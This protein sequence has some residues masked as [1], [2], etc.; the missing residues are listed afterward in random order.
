MYLSDPGGHLSTSGDISPCFRRLWPKATPPIL[1]R[2]PEIQPSAGVSEPPSISAA[3]FRPQG[4]TWRLINFVYGRQEFAPPPKTAVFNGGGIRNSRHELRSSP[5]GRA[6]VYYTAADKDGRADYPGGTNY[7]WR[8][9]KDEHLRCCRQLLVGPPVIIRPAR[10]LTTCIVL[11]PGPN[12]ILVVSSYSGAAGYVTFGDICVGTRILWRVAA[13]RAAGNN[14]TLCCYYV[15]APLPPL[16][17]CRLAA[18]KPPPAFIRR[19]R[20]RWQPLAAAYR[21]LGGQR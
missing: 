18:D 6:A 7:S 21:R 19:R 14:N 2:R 8:L 16:A 9:I 10:E 20:L 12:T 17:T 5:F 4:R 13:V 1:S 11:G 15:A 3:C